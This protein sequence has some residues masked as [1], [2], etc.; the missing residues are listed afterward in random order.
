[1]TDPF[2]EIRGAL[3]YPYRD[4]PA[5][6]LS[7]L[8]ESAGFTPEILEDIFG[9]ISSA[10]RAIGKGVQQA[11]PYAAPIVGGAAQGLL[12]GAALGPV[13]MIG[14]AALGATGAAVA[15]TQAPAPST[16]PRAAP[17]PPIPTPPQAG[18]GAHAPKAVPAAGQTLAAMMQPQVHQA[19]MAMLLGQL[20]TR[21][22]TVGQQQVPVA[23][24]PN[25]LSALAS[26]AAAQYHEAVSESETDASFIPGIAESEDPQERADQ[27]LDLLQQEAEQGEPWG[28]ESWDEEYES[29]SLEGYDPIYGGR[30]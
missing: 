14:G 25:M 8:L 26:R 21:M 19:L 4:L 11:M 18:V 9:T 1:M 23:A 28:F 13:G 17:A 12:G 16:V 24:I 5:E 6:E 15:A 29:T 22:V 3:A 7:P 2:G 27:V 20:G 10:G 30:E